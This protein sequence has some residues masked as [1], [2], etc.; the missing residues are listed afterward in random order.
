MENV[1]SRSSECGRAVAGEAEATQRLGSCAN[2]E[3]PVEQDRFAEEALD[4][5]SYA[6]E[7]YPVVRRVAEFELTAS[8]LSNA[9]CSVSRAAEILGDRWS[10][11]IMREAF[12][13]IKRFDEFQ[14]FVGLSPN[15]LS[16]RL[17]KMVEAGVF[18]RIPLPDHSRRFEYRLTDMGRDFFPAYLALKKW[19]DDWLAE[20]AG[21]Q[22]EFRHRRSGRPVEM[23]R[24]LT[25]G[26][27]QLQFEDVE[28]VPGSGAVPFNRRRFGKATSD[29]IASPRS[30]TSSG[31]SRRSVV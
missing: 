15:I 19:G 30:K 12:Y 13:G 24:L 17:G 11:L 23:P 28:V 16:D 25:K 21:P 4:G 27:R 2:R 8:K 29:E 3:F 7:V 22:V 5:W 9:E 26:G 10:L 14:K 1:A 20:T 31:K 6:D 18:E